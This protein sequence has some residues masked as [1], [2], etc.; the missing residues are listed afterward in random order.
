M[1][2]LQTEMRARAVHDIQV[3]HVGSTTIVAHVVVALE[4]Q[5]TVSHM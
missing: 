1:V 3:Q 5:S 4:I 2:T